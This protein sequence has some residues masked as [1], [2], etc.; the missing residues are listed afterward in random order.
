MTT[1]AEAVGPAPEA[2]GSAWHTLSAERVLHAE[3]VDGQRGLSSAE[4]A[5]RAQRFGPNAFATGQVESRW[6]VRAAVRRPDADRLA[7]GGEGRGGRGRPVAGAD[8]PLGD[9]TDMV[10]MN[11]N[12]T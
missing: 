12:V 11:T 1:A 4:V 10:Y 2:D 7:G 6:H 3:E 5:A 8:T 9:R